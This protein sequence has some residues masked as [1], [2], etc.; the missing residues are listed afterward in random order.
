MLLPHTHDERGGI[1]SMGVSQ[2]T[3]SEVSGR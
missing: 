1:I 3:S 2:L